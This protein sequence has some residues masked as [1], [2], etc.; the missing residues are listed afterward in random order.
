MQSINEES[1]IIYLIIF[2]NGLLFSG[3][4][5][6]FAIRLIKKIVKI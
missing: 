6:N 2:S 5:L 4:F 1:Q 3:I